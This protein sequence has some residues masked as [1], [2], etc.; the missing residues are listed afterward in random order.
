M[1]LISHQHNPDHLDRL[2]AAAGLGQGHPP[3][4]S[5]RRARRSTSFGAGFEDVAEVAP[6]EEVEVGQPSPR[7]A[8]LTRLTRGGRG[9][10][11]TSVHRDR[12]TSLEG[13]RRLYLRG[14]DTDVFPEMAELRRL[15]HRA[16]PDLGL[17]AD[18]RPRPPQP[19]ERRRRGRAPC[20]NA[21]LCRSTG[22][23][24]RP[25]HLTLR[26]RPAFLDDPPDLF[27]A[28]LAGRRPGRRARRAPPRRVD[29][30]LAPARRCSMLVEAL[31][32]RRI[33]SLRSAGRRVFHQPTALAPCALDE[34]RRDHRRDDR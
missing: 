24:M 23:H 33:A 7:A 14:A 28:A 29:D 12:R 1:V 31:V 10:A 11:G 25:A 8:N 20:R 6:G 21:S 32:D 30:R 34:R 9:C 16:A 2:L 17:G 19:R 4:S 5:R 26:S 27:R 3:A 15:R 13:R 18:P 22:A